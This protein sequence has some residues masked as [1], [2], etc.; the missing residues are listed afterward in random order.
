[1]KISLVVACV[2]GPFFLLFST[3]ILGVFGKQY[4]IAAAAMAILGFTIYPI[5]IKA[6]PSLSLG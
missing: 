3:S 6:I 2:S 1:M 5:A 4:E